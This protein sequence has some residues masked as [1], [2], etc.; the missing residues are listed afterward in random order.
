MPGLTFY[1]DPENPPFQN[2]QL[3]FNHSIDQISN[4]KELQYYPALNLDFDF[5]F[6][7]PAEHLGRALAVNHSSPGSTYPAKDVHD[8]ALYLPPGHDA[9][10]SEPYPVLYLSHGGGGTA[11]DWPNLAKAFNIID[12]LI[13]D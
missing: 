11:L 12:N 1:N 9:N 13:L 7:V 10:C 2:D 6:P 5:A 3:Q 4:D 8:L